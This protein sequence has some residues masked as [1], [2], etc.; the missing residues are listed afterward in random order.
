MQLL[1]QESW[2]SAIH[3]K[4]SLRYVVKHGVIMP[5]AFA[6]TLTLAVGPDRIYD[7]LTYLDTAILY[8][9]IEKSLRN[10]IT[11]DTPSNQDAI[12]L[13]SVKDRNQYLDKTPD[14]HN[15]IFGKDKYSEPVDL[16]PELHSQTLTTAADLQNRLN[17]LLN[18]SSAP[19]LPRNALNNVLVG[20][21]SHRNSLKTLVKD[22]VVVFWMLCV[23]CS[24][25]IE[26]VFQKRREH[27][28]K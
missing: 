16:S 4:K 14:S 17:L 1:S 3:F 22:M 5:R 7:F 21:A 8:E 9:S 20:F 11:H 12:N 6:V 26:S 13:K 23:T 24:V 19:A 2:L 25:A 27:K 10:T 15:V 18:T 28:S